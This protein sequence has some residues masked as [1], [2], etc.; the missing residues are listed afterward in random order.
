MHDVVEGSADA[1]NAARTSL[2]CKL[3]NSS[4]CSTSSPAVL[5]KE[6]FSCPFSKRFNIVSGYGFSKRQL[7][8]LS[9]THRNNAMP[10]AV[11]LYIVLRR[12]LPGKRPS[13]TGQHFREFALEN[14]A[15][16]C[17]VI[18][19]ACRSNRAF[20]YLTPVIIRYIRETTWEE[21]NITHWSGMLILLPVESPELKNLKRIIYSDTFNLGLVLL[22]HE[23]ISVNISDS[24]IFY[25]S[26]VTN[27]GEQ[28]M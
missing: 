26:Y 28:N 22:K 21:T 25:L 15:G 16:Y 13:V 27:S 19:P 24:V 14:G 10:K 9:S 20:L 8:W 6:G 11:S 3:I 5:R 4:L 12:A 17:F 2:A 1:A 7:K 23:N 18:T